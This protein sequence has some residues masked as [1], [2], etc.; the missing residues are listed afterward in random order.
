M[1]KKQAKWCSSPPIVHWHGLM[2]WSKDRS[3]KDERWQD[4]RYRLWHSYHQSVSWIF[5]SRSRRFV[6]SYCR[7]SME[8]MMWTWELGITLFWFCTSFENFELSDQTWCGGTLTICDSV[9]I[10]GWHTRKHTCAKFACTL[11]THTH[12]R[13]HTHK[14]THTHVLIESCWASDLVWVMAQRNT[15]LCRDCIVTEP[16]LPVLFLRA[17]VTT[18][19]VS[20]LSLYTLYW[21]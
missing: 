8:S 10:T 12:T 21:N 6:R 3:T 14:H 20:E 13:K 2:Q 19:V 15:T 11:G 9:W 18:R 5:L 17:C 16:R 1:C 7:G 4:P